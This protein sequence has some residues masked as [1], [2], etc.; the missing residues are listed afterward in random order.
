MRRLFRKGERV[1]NKL[2][3]KVMEVL[4]YIKSNVV[5]V[6]WFD[7]DAKEVRTNTVKEDKLSKAA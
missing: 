7:L 5:E 6:K 4:R 2:D 3:G 1:R